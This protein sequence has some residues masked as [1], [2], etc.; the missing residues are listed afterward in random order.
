MDAKLGLALDA[1]VS[2]KPQP[3]LPPRSE[4]SRFQED[5]D[6]DVR[7]WVYFGQ[8]FG[9]RIAKE[10]RPEDQHVFRF[11]L[12]EMLFNQIQSYKQQ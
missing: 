7:E 6:P 10:V 4:P 12:E 8:S 5:A 11:K 2:S 1:L 9:R 3:H